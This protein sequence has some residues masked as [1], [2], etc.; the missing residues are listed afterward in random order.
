MGISHMKVKHRPHKRALNQDGALA[1]RDAAPQKRA[2][3]NL[4][5]APT[6]GAT[7]DSL[8]P[9]PISWDTSCL[10]ATKLD[11]YL[12]APT[13]DIARIHLYTNV[14]NVAASSGSTTATYNAELMPRWWNATDSQQLTIS[15]VPVNQPPFTS[16]FAAGPIFTA[17]YKAPAD[18]STP[19]VA[20]TT[21]FSNGVTDVS[22]ALSANK[23]SITPG[24][25]AAAALF[26]LLFVIGLGVYGYIRWKRT[27]EAGKRKEWTEKVDSRMS[28]ISTDWKA[29]SAA[30]ANAAV[31]HS[32]AV[33]RAS[34]ALARQSGVNAFSVDESAIGSATNPDARERS[35]LRTGVGL[36]NPAGLTSGERVSRVS[37]A[38]DNRPSSSGRISFADTVNS[39]PSGERSR[40]GS[41]A[42]HTSV[43][44]ADDGDMVP[45]VP[46]LPAVAS[47]REKNEREQQ[48]D[49][50][51]SPR[52]R[53]G[54]LALTPEDIRARINASKKEEGFAADMMPALSMMRTGDASNDDYLL[55]ASP[56]P[57]AHHKINT[58][59][60][61]APQRV[62]SP[63]MASMPM[64]PMPASVMSPDAMLRAYAERKAA[65]AA[66]GRVASP[67][68]THSPA[69]SG[70]R[71]RS[72]A[73]TPISY[74]IP[75][76]VAT[77]AGATGMR[78]LYDQQETATYSV[79]SGAATAG[80]GSEEAYYGGAYGV[81]AQSAAYT[82]SEYSAVENYNQ[83]HQESNG[84]YA[85]GHHANGSI[86]VGAYGGAQYAIG[87]D[88]ED[89]SNN[90]AGRGAGMGR[91]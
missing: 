53:E 63:V 82:A 9:L 55:P 72:L 1:A 86:G 85:F 79:N 19:A 73:G 66:A 65:A 12:I 62:A 47:L 74:P 24:G 4:Y 44:N 88:E 84:A 64:Q 27:K 67:V 38:P 61:T 49:G 41:R 75:G 11:I 3:C 30:G 36:R 89:G 51:F 32:I 71:K 83:H 42:F 50:S 33:S 87:E 29:V 56:P 81:D 31:R 26:P 5:Q 25:K 10:N 23:S 7:V 91:A 17:T 60:P 46:A 20:D 78:V 15:I 22:A 16:A 2:L 6:M 34:M 77:T 21:V 54:A 43:Y 45:P 58:S 28:T 57:A 90:M 76:A 39:R 69:S 68:R 35:Q 8:A 18:G 48:D 14:P 37:F 80:S 59:I 40:G 52:Q 70:G 13:A